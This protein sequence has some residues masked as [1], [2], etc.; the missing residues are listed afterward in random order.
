[1][2]QLFYY[3]KKYPRNTM[4]WA[5]YS[6]KKRSFGTTIL[7]YH[8]RTQLTNEAVTNKRNN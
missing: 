8:V 5:E 7:P 1:M 4:Q 3:L 6:N 2:R